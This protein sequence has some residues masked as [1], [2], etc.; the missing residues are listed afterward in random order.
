MGYV[1]YRRYLYDGPVM[2]F[3]RVITPRWI[4]YT[5]APSAAK[6]KSN[7]AYR[8]KKDHGKAPTAK[9]KLPGVIR[10]IEDRR[11]ND[12]EQLAFDFVKEIN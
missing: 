5:V 8:Y 4:G 12:G 9:I 1:D 2:E 6:A 11:Y 7:L 10:V 3:G